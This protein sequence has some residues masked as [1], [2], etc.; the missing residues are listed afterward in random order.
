MQLIAQEVKVLMKRCWKPTSDRLQVLTKE[1]V[2]TYNFCWMTDLLPG[3]CCCIHEHGN[4]V[5]SD[6]SVWKMDL[7]RLT[8]FCDMINL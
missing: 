5:I 8:K 3:R 1:R 4:T 7:A 2:I 6:V